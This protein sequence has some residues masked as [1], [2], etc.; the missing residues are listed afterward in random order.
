MFIEFD[1]RVNQYYVVLEGCV[2]RGRFDLLEKWDMSKFHDGN[3]YRL[4]YLW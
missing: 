1:G 3:I 2:L 4:S